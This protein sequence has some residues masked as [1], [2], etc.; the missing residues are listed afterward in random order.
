MYKTKYKEN[1]NLIGQNWSLPFIIASLTGC[2]DF[3]SPIWPTY[4]FFFF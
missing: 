1:K 3:V 2:D 4:S